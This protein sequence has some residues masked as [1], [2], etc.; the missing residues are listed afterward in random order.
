MVSRGGSSIYIYDVL[1]LTLYITLS[2][3][4]ALATFLDVHV[5]T[6]RRALRSG[7]VTA[8]KW[9]LSTV[10]LRVETLK[11]IARSQTVKS[12]ASKKIYVYNVNNTVSHPRR[13]VM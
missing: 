7:K 9:I 3:L 2:G 4:T 13:G 11:I 12:T 8:K 5:N 10:E 1:S 6:A